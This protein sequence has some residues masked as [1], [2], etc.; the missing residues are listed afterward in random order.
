MTETVS[1]PDEIQR[2]RAAL[3][4]AMLQLDLLGHKETPAYGFCAAALDPDGSSSRPEDWMLNFAGAVHSQMTANERTIEQLCNE[5]TSIARTASAENMRAV[6]ERRVRA[7][8]A[9][10]GSEVTTVAPDA[11][12]TAAR[13]DYVARSLRAI[14][15]RGR[16]GLGESYPELVAL[17]ATVRDLAVGAA[18]NPAAPRSRKV[19]RAG[20][21]RTG[22]VLTV[23]LDADNDVSVNVWDDRG[24]GQVEFCVVGEEA[25]NSSATRAALLALMAAMEVDNSRDPTRA[26]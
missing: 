5:L 18:D 17:W 20:D 16:D 4:G 2:L 1:H 10:R 21:Q 7:A 15:D 3:S 23:S 12:S 19:G 8:I 22:A 25:G 11:Q 14:A 6:I 9:S 26:W 13:L 24:G